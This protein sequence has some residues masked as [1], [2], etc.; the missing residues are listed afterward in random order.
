MTARRVAA[1]IAVTLDGRYHG[2][3]GPADMAPIVPFA[4]TETA[5]NHLAQIHEGVTTAV[6]SRGNAEGFLGWWSP[7]ADDESADPRDR[8]YA[9]WLVDVEKV[10]LSSTRTELPHPNTRVLDAPAADV[11]VELKASGTGDILVNTAPSILKPLLAADLV[12]RL[13][14]VVTP[15]IAGGGARLFEDGLPTTSWSLTSHAS[16]DLGEQALVYD[17]IR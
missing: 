12:D 11:V 2:P 8:G 4:V 14:L 7:I 16:G 5:R 10:V 15:V 17:R 3:G 1:N 9:R 6:L 13:F